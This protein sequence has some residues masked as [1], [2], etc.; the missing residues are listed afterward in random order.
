[1]AGDACKGTDLISA[2]DGV[3]HLQML[4]SQKPLRHVKQD[5]V[6]GSHRPNA[7]GSVCSSGADRRTV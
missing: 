2:D 5:V 1:V 3:S 6:D 7:C 4:D